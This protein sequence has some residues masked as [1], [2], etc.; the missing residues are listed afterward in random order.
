KVAAVRGPVAKASDGVA[1]GAPSDAEIRR[2]LQAA[3]GASQVVNRASR[4]PD[5]LAGVPASAP[6]A[7]ESIIRAAN[8]VALL[9]YVYG[10]CHARWDDSADGRSA[11]ETVALAAPR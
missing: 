1:A 11:A 5:G 7:V 4:S 2:E 9:P 3:F 10:G 8:A 6:H